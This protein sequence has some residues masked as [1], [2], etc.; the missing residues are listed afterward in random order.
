MPSNAVSASLA[1]CWETKILQIAEC[2]QKVNKQKLSKCLIQSS[3]HA[4]PVLDII[5]E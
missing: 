5:I 2:D 3:G 4:G 1:A